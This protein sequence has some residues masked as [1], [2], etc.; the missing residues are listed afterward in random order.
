MPVLTELASRLATV[1]RRV[2]AAAERGGRARSAVTVVAVSKRFDADAVRA[3]LHAGHTDFG[4]SRAQELRRKAADVGDGVRWHF[5]GRLQRNKVPELVGLVSLVHSVDRIELAEALA[6][7]TR[8][9]TNGASARVQRVL[10]QV[11]A[12]E[13]PRKGGCRVADAPALVAAVRQLDGLA[14]EGLMTVPPMGED[15]RPVFARLRRLRDE[16]CARFPE[17]VQL[18]MGMTDDFEVAI[19]EGATIVRVGE[20]IFGPRPA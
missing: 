7:R 1:D 19:E 9:G 10:I 11:N 3:A 2:A 18:S 20:A 4:E 12:G 5:V 8:A 13:D 14:C 6:A 17:V 16:L 15:P